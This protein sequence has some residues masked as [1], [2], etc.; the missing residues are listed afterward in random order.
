[1]GLK[2]VFNHAH[3]S[4]R[5]VIERSFGVLKLKWRILLNLPS[6]PVNK[7]SKIIVACMAPHNFIREC[8]LEDPHFKEDI[9]DDSPCPT[10]DNTD[11]G[12]TRDDVDIAMVS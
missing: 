4:L 1:M 11:D 3:S 9:E 7:Q 2:E 6:Y 12:G 5:N 8:D 10:Y